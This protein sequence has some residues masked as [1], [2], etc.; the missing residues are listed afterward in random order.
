MEYYR[1]LAK[2][3]ELDSDGLPHCK[4][5]DVQAM[6]ERYPK[7]YGCPCGNLNAWLRLEVFEHYEMQCD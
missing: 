7:T 2:C 3:P 6:M 5:A 1:C 4:T